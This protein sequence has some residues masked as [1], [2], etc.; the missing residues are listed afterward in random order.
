ML[1]RTT[2]SVFSLIMLT[3]IMPAY[4]IDLQRESEVDRS[5]SDFTLNET[6]N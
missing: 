3:A 4:S 2:T 6:L 5:P 1:T